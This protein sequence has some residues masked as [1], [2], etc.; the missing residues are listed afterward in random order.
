MAPFPVPAR[1]T[2]H[3]DFP[4]PAFRL[5]SS[6]GPRRRSKVQAAETLHTE[7]SEDD[8]IGE[9]P[10]AAPWHVVPSAEERAHTVIDVVVDSSIGRQ[11]RAVAEVGSPAEQEPVQPAAHLGPRPFVAGDQEIADL[12]LDPL[13]TL[14]RRAGAKIPMAVLPVV[15]RPNV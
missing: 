9:A 12:R 8:V 6:Q 11:A 13:Y 5:A 1:Q 15:V 7:L 3:A 4:H 14:L 10:G 2:G